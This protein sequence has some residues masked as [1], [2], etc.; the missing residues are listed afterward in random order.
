MATP[1]LKAYFGEQTTADISGN[2][3]H[4]LYQFTPACIGWCLSASQHLPKFGGASLSVNLTTFWMAHLPTKTGSAFWTNLHYP[5][6]KL[7]EISLNLQFIWICWRGPKNYI[8]IYH[9]SAIFFPIEIAKKN[10]FRYQVPDPYQTFSLQI[11]ELSRGNRIAPT[12]ERTFHF[13]A[14]LDYQRLNPIREMQVASVAFQFWSVL[15]VRQ[16]NLK[17]IP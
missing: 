5:F 2:L 12:I 17:K 15:L 1:A 6:V 16:F 10:M 4:Q 9:S 14:M 3:Y 7:A 11:L 13:S 8:Y